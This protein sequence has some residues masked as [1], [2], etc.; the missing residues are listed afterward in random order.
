[1]D[2]LTDARTQIHVIR[3]S[4]NQIRMAFVMSCTNFVNRPDLTNPKMAAW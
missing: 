2:G 4:I 3:K 1:M